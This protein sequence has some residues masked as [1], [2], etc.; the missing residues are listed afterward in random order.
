MIGMIRYQQIRTLPVGSEAWI[1]A[2]KKY[3]LI[4]ITPEQETVLRDTGSVLY[5]FETDPCEDGSRY[6]CDVRIATVGEYSE[7]NASITYTKL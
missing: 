6:H 1:K 7:N 4:R 2:V 5:S 3:A